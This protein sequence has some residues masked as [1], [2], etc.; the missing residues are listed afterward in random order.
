MI[1]SGTITCTFTKYNGRS[2]FKHAIG[3]LYK[4]FSYIVKL[5]YHLLRILCVQK[6]D[7]GYVFG[8]ILSVDDLAT[9]KS[10]SAHHALV[11]YFDR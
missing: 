1:L 4:K 8:Q 9:Q 11:K 6:K 2:D 5:F 3:S 10:A 7:T